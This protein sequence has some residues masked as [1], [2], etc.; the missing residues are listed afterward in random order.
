MRNSFQLLL[1]ISFILAICSC[2]DNATS[3]KS[4]IPANKTSNTEFQSINFATSP[5]RLDG[6]ATDAAW[7]NAE[8][9]PI[10]Q[11]WLGEPMEPGDFEGRFK[12]LWSEDKL[13]ILAETKDDVLMDIHEDDLVQYWDDDCLELFIDEDNSDG[14][15]QYTHNAFAYHISTKLRVTD[16]GRDGKPA[17]FDHHM[18]S[19][20]TR[21]NRTS[22]WEVAMNV[23]SDD[24]TFGSPPRKLAEG[25]ELGFMVAYCDNDTSEER[26]NFIGS[27]AI[28]GEDKNRGWIDA[29]VFNNWKLVK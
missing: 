12:L 14:D 26:E 24:Y 4:V 28:E 7:A 19:S 20:V 1:F 25:E 27:I 5:V 11:V 13:F 21:T 8:W 16:M 15:H 22:T 18:Q 23:Y 17:F 10:D 6:L 3:Q 2:A 29:G 9:H